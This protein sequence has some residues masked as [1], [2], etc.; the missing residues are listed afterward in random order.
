MTAEKNERILDRSI[1]FVHTTI[2]ILC[3]SIGQ[4]KTEVELS[5]KIGWIAMLSFVMLSSGLI[6]DWFSIIEEL[7]WACQV[8]SLK[9]ALQEAQV[10]NRRWN[11]PIAWL[12]TKFCLTKSIIQPFACNFISRFFISSH[13]LVHFN[14]S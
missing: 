14:Y 1:I 8:P 3:L 6:I 11:R 9:R 2:K 4:N 5:K 7:L 12:L 13:W 10:T